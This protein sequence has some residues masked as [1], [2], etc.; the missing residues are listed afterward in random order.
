[1]LERPI[2][3]AKIQLLMEEQRQKARE[4]ARGMML[5]ETCEAKGRYLHDVILLADVEGL[6]EAE[7]DLNKKRR[8]HG[9]CN[10]LF[11]YMIL[12]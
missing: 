11:L 10:R 7:D 8:T 1:M 3:Y 4:K 9:P 12:A 5:R 6:R 2:P